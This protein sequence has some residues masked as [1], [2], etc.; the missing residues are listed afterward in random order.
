MKDR[1]TFGI[2]FVPSKRPERVRYFLRCVLRALVHPPGC[3]L[4]QGTSRAQR[5]KEKMTIY[6]GFGRDFEKL[7]ETRFNP[8]I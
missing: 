6:A 2:H 8:V 7:L 3:K 5:T 1:A 4:S